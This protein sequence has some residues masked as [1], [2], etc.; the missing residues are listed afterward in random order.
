MASNF[1]YMVN[2]EPN[3]ENW[4]T[5]YEDNESNNLFLGDQTFR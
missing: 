2:F 4:L 1:D 5:F 3:I